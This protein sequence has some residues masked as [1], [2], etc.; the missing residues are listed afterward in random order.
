MRCIDRNNEEIDLNKW[1][2]LERLPY[3]QGVDI[4]YLRSRYRLPDQEQIFLIGYQR[5][6]AD[7]SDRRTD[8]EKIIPN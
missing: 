3:K 5:S 4:L 6:D 7:S 8:Q 1:E 2:I